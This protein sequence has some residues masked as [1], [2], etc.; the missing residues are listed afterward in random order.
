[1]RWLKT[2]LREIYGLFVDDGVFAVAI[3]V[4]LLAAWLASPWIHIPLTWRGPILC[5]GLIL[6]LVESATRY[7][8]S[9]SR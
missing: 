3:V 8:R 2:G 7:A 9:R 6:I 4:W 1:M 5:A